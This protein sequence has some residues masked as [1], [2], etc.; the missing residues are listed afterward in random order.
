MSDYTTFYLHGRK[1]KLT[2][3]DEAIMFNVLFLNT[4]TLCH[5]SGKMLVQRLDDY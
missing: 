4:H 5:W 3:N 1:K 2:Q